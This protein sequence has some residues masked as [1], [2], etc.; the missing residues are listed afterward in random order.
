MLAEQ[1]DREHCAVDTTTHEDGGIVRRWLKHADILG[2]LRPI[3]Q[4]GERGT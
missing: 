3:Q 1:V 4:Q 2:R